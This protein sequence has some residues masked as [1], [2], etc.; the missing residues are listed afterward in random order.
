MTFATNVLVALHKVITSLTGLAREKREALYQPNHKGIVYGIMRVDEAV[1]SNSGIWISL[2]MMV[3][4]YVGM[5]AAATRVLL[6]MARRWREDDAVDLPTPYGPS[7]E[8][9]GTGTSS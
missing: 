3:V 6:G 8:V 4:V 7:S 5:A 9:V 1:T 2:A